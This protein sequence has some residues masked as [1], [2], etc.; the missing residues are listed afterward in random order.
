[1]TALRTLALTPPNAAG[2]GLRRALDR[3][4]GRL[5]VRSAS[6]MDGLP[7]LA[8]VQVIV[9]HLAGVPLSPNER[10]ALLT[11]VASGGGLVT[12][13]DRG[14]LLDVTDAALTP[15]C[16]LVVTTAG[17]HPITARLDPRMTVIDACALLPERLDGEVILQLSWQFR[18][19]PLAVVRTIGRGRLITFALHG[20]PAAMADP[21]VQRLVYRA[22]RFA[23][24][25]VARRPVGAALVGWGAIGIAHASALEETAGLRLVTVC[26][27]NPER[28][29]E[30]QRDFP[31]VR[32]ASGL[33]ALLA[34]DDVELA[35]VSTPPNSHLPIA[36]RLLEAGKHVVVEKPFCLTTAEADRLIALAERQ[37][38]ALTVYQNR[39]WD[40]DYLAIRA[41]IESGAIGD[42]FHIETFIGSFDHPCDFW[43]SHQPVSGGLVYDWGSHYLDWILG[44]VA[45]PV[46][47]VSA[48]R[49]KRVWHDVTNDDMAR[50][51]IRF[52]GGVEAEFIHSDVAAALKPKWYILGERGA[53][54]ADWRRERV[55]RRARTGE[56]IEEPLQPAESPAVVSV[57]RRDRSGAIHVERLHL[58]VPPR[59][60]FHRNLA[61]HLLDGEPLAVTP[62]Q[63]RRNV[64]VMEAALWSA[65]HDASPVPVDDGGH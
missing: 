12:F 61:D 10:A 62:Q 18:R 31:E 20:G 13:G 55:V 60:A 48:S 39:R 15:E 63:A 2:E 23:A 64:A 4:A 52:E 54:V 37:R 7:D 59:W 56:L 45:A 28:L 53:V 22:V 16:E 33:E 19:L 44:L 24:G 5:D 35:I 14:V 51:L 9:G 21:S 46:R 49:H 8:G 38:R 41:T 1:V 17:E 26:D 6:V 47:T 11:F 27:Q 50:I 29:A 25:E 40:A 65:T 42:P 30:A 58:P 43:H 32:T 3:Y 36:E 34:A 57:H